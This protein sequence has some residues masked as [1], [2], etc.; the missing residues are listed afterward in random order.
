M[1][2]KWNEGA[3]AACRNEVA[4]LRQAFLRMERGLDPALCSADTEKGTG[5][6]PRPGQQ[7]P[8]DLTRSCPRNQLA[9]GCSAVMSQRDD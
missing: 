4:S 7:S 2:R 9:C 1:S 5:S 3:R 8:R 6:F